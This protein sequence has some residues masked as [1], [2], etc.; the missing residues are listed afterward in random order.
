MCFIAA[1]QQLF[2][3]Q[4]PV[5]NTTSQLDGSTSSGV[6]TNT[7]NL[8]FSNQSESSNSRA[9]IEVV[10]R[11]DETLA[12]YNLINFSSPFSASSP[13]F[14]DKIRF[15][16]TVS[17][18][19][20]TTVEVALYHNPSDLAAP[21]DLEISMYSNCPAT[22]STTEGQACGSGIGTL[23]LGST[24]TLSNFLPPDGVYLKA[25]EFL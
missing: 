24:M 20:I 16:N 5:T 10:Y 12:T 8:V 22:E 2:S 3:Q 17:N 1:F 21:I 15:T 25:F 9:P 11:T 6:I 19:L 18:R 4:N 13:K 7:S 14:G 23:I